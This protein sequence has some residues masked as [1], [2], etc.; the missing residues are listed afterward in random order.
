MVSLTDMRGSHDS[1]R[2]GSNLRNWY[3]RGSETRSVLLILWKIAVRGQKAHFWSHR[4]HL[5]RMRRP[6]RQNLRG[7]QCTDR[8]WKP[9]TYPDRDTSNTSEIRRGKRRATPNFTAPDGRRAAQA[10]GKLGGYRGGAGRLASSGLGPVFLPRPRTIMTLQMSTANSPSADGTIFAADDLQQLFG[11]G[12]PGVALKV[13]SP[14]CIS[15]TRSQI[16]KVCA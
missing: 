5:R 11:R 10:R 9:E 14:C 1:S 12:R 2:R 13:T 3:R 16:S 4:V 7:R 6:L 8:N 15:I